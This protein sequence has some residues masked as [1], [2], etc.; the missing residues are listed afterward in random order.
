M[1][2]DINWFENNMQPVLVDGLGNCSACCLRNL[3]KDLFCKKLICVDERCCNFVFWDTKNPG[4]HRELLM[5]LPSKDMTEWFRKTSVRRVQEITG[6][7]I[8]KALQNQK[9]NVK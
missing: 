3:D 2:Y 6:D 7:M 8:N 1:A 5:G 4:Q 9:Q